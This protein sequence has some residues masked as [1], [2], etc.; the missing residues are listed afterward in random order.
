MDPKE[1]RKVREVQKTPTKT[2]NYA[3]DAFV[4]KTMKEYYIYNDRGFN[5][6]D[7]VVGPATTGLKVSPDSIIHTVSGLT[8]TNGSM[9]LSYLHKAI[10][11][12][13]QL[14]TLEDATVIYRISRAPERRI[15]YIDVGNLP[16]MKAEQYVREIMVKHKNRLIYDAASGEVRDDRKFMTMLEDYWL[17]RREGGRGTEVTTLPGGQNLGEIEDV[18]YFQ[19]KFLQALN[20][21]VDRLAPE[22]AFS[23]GRAT[24]ITRDEVKFGKFIIRLRSRFSHLFLTL[25]EKQLILKGILT[26]DEWNSLSP[27]IKFRFAKDNYFTELKNAEIIQNRL[28]VADSFQNYAGKYYSHYYIRKNVLRQSEEDIKEQDAYI[29]QEGKLQDPRWVNPL[30]VQN[31]QALQQQDQSQE[32]PTD[33]KFSHLDDTEKNKAQDR[34]QKVRQAQI[35]VKQLESKKG[36]RSMQ[37]EAKYKSALQVVAKNKD[38]LRKMGIVID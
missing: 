19:K 17:P 27:L 9:V 2:N 36:N 30:I 26:V 20:V 33:D 38:Y 12:L 24:Q 11:P 16:K 21:P 35:L 13:N 25:L 8:D 14:S 31:K 28:S 4:A 1:I 15:W 34:L 37:D 6:N 18:L 29:N 3:Y 7:K 32:Q 23:V 22:T 5:F 10:K